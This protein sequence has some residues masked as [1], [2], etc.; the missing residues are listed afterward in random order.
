MKASKG[1]LLTL[2]LIVFLDL[3]G[4]GIVLPVLA[5]LFLDTDSTLIPTHWSQDFRTIAFGFFVA[6]YPLA[7]FFGAPIL[8]KLSDRYGRKK[9]LIISLTGTA[10]GYLL[11]AFGLWQHTLWILFASRL[12]DG[13]TGG[14][15]AVA[16]SAIADLSPDEQSRAKNFGLIGMAFGMGFILGPFIG[17]VLG[18]STILPWFGP[19]LPFLFAAS[20]S[21]INFAMI[22]WVL[23]ETLK[24]PMIGRFYLF[25]GLRNLGQAFKL[26][27][28][29]VMFFVT[30]LHAFGFTFFTHFFSVFLVQKFDYSS[31]EIGFF[32]GYV[33]LWIALSQGLFNRWVLNFFKSE[34]ILKFAFFLLSISLFLMVLPSK[35]AWLYLLQPLVAM[36]EGITFPNVTT[37][38]SKLSRDDQQG[39]ALGITQSIR[40]F[41]EAFPPIISGF[42]VTINPNMPILVAAGVI[43]FAGL[44]YVLLFKPKPIL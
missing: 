14:N 32:Y 16:N 7:Q 21:L 13:F 15:I 30:F 19:M 40:A 31:S 3:I 36:A 27:D 8:G 12:L 41:A 1:A 24:T 20:L 25:A 43:F 9:L 11:F 37:V 28:L 38:I 33:G 6:T 5:P 22:I 42:L 34:R 35:V 10:L 18:D 2:F 23:P 4:I 17:G 26:Q 44:M 39:E 29:R